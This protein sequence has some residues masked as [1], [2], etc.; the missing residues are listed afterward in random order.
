[1]WVTKLDRKRSFVNRAYV[2]FLG[3]S[4]EEAVDFDWRTVIHPDDARANPRRIRSPA[5]RR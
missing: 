5:R 1:M 4:Y 2:E 3:I